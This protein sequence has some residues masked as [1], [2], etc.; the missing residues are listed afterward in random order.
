M[1][2]C[3]GCGLVKP[4]AKYSPSKYWEDGT[5]RQPASRC[6]EC[7][8]KATCARYPEYRSRNRERLNAYNSEWNRKKRDALRADRAN[9]AQRMP[10]SPLQAFLW[11][12]FLS[13]ED[14]SWLDLGRQC[15]MEDDRSIRRV[16]TQKHVSLRLA[17]QVCTRLGGN[18]SVLYP[19][20]EAA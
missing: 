13:M 6:H 11:E 15:G 2:K 18:L 7:A 20:L 14:P 16:L 10:A 17:D 9:N 5:V 3:P 1:K 12:R 4:W 19:D 8:S